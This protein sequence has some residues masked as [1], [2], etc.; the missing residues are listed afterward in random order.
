M[1]QKLIFLLACFTLIVLNPSVHRA[2]TAVSP[3]EMRSGLAEKLRDHPEQFA[4][5]DAK[6]SKRMNKIA[7]RLERKMLKHGFQV[8][9]SDPVDQWLWFGI[10]GLG[11]AILLSFFNIGVGGLIAFLAVVCLVI[12]VVKRGAV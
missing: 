2:A 11:I 12:W 4:G 6:T 10:F 3:Q 9:F 1:N 7:K 5:N 8:D